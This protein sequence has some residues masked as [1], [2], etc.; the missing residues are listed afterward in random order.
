M[1]AVLGMFLKSCVDLFRSIRKM[2][3]ERREKS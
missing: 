1:A 2:I 3:Q